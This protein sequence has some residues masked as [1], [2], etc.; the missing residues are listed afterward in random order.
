MSGVSKAVKLISEPR[1]INVAQIILYA[2]GAA[3]GLAAVIG[4]LS[5]LFTSTTVGPWVIIVSGSFL[6]AGGILGTI[7]VVA[8]MWWLECVALVSCGVGWGVLVP[9]ATYYAVTTHNS[10]IWIVIALLVAVLCDVYKRYRRIDWAYLD[11]TR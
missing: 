10:A 6:T 3:A 11:P 2:V 8:G 5:P 1:G 9:A 4:S 7:G